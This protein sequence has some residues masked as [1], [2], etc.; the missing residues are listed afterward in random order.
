MEM[1]SCE[2]NAATYRMMVIGKKNLS[3]VS[4]AWESLLC[5]LCIKDGGFCCEA[6]LEVIST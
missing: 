4:S 3:F 1:K 2:P 6:L 5:D